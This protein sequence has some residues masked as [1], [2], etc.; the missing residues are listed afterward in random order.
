M[1]KKVDIAAQLSAKMAHAL[2]GR[3][4]RGE[5][6][7]TAL[8]RLRELADPEAPPELALKAVGKP[9]LSSH[10][11]VANKKSLAAPVALREDLDRFAA[12]PQVLEFALETLSAA[13]SPPW[14]LSKVSGQLDKALRESFE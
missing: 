1:P 4:A 6:Y 13:G 5:E 12:S 7:P 8:G 3:R 10:A 9:P 14:P 11:V 2:E